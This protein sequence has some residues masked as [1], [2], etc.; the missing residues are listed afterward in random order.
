MVDDIA[1]GV[2]SHCVGIA[3]APV[4]T[5]VGHHHLSAVLVIANLAEL[6]VLQTWQVNPPSTSRREHFA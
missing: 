1:I 2:A 4:V 6:A 5:V 3:L